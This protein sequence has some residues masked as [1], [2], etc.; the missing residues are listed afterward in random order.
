MG[1]TLPSAS[2][3]LMHEISNYS[4]FKRTLAPRDQTALDQ[5][6]VYANLHV[7]EAAYASFELPMETFLLAMLLEMHKEVIHLRKEIESFSQD[8]SSGS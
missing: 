3:L 7:A 5:L 8:V 1:R 2:M 6:F 4:S